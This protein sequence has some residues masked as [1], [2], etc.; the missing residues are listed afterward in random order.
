MRL[1]LS[2]VN[3][4]LAF[5]PPDN[6]LQS[7]SGN[8]K[9]KERSEENGE[10]TTSKVTWKEGSASRNRAPKSILRGDEGNACPVRTFKRSQSTLRILDWEKLY[11]RKRRDQC[12]SHGLF[13]MV[14]P[15][16]LRTVRV[17]Q[18]FVFVRIFCARVERALITRLK[19]LQ[20]MYSVDTVRIQ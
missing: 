8:I 12:H 7:S 10:V 2:H 13:D 18:S 15:S 9:C 17:D 6:P 14:P 4:L 16:R 20:C 19:S 3:P 5:S 1:I 11:V